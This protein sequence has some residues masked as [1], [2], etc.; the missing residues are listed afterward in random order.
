M[1]STTGTTDQFSDHIVVYGADWC[2]DCRATKAILEAALVEFEYVDLMADEDAPAKAEAIS[3][4]KH[5][6]V[7]VF[8]DGVFYVE[9]TKIELGLKLR[10]LQ[11][12]HA[13]DELTV[14]EA[15]SDE[16]AAVEA[17]PGDDQPATDADEARAA[18]AETTD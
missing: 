9:P 11:A 7:V 8:P 4:Q 17:G 2:P 18:E 10:A 15:A 6:P 16:S 3:G 12:D 1:A 14:D 13:A 5:I